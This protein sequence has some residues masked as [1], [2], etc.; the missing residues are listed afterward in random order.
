[1]NLTDP[2]STIMTRDL[3]TITESEL[4][5]TVER[6]FKENRIHHIPVVKGNRLMGMLSKSDYLLFKRGFNDFSIDKIDDLFRLKTHTVGKI[7]TKGIAT[8]QSNERIAVAMEIFN[9]NRF[10][11]IPIMDGDKLVGIVSTYD[12]IKKL[13]IDRGA[14]T[15]YN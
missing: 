7:M 12:I 14:I 2:V 6:I 10:H 15:E 11:A 4:L 13:S 5:N 9:E 3:I 8:L 1:M